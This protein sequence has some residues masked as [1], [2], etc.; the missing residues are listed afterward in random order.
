ML[1]LIG[2]D[3]KLLEQ[4]KQNWRD[5]DLDSQTRALLE[6]AERLT[7]EPSSILESD[8]EVLRA[9]GLSDE[10]ILDAV[11]IMS[12]MNFSNRISSGL[13]VEPGLKA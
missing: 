11:L 9:N 10:Q 2:N 13:G 1:P 5:I 7:R 6:F 12:E 4:L 8:I 3:R